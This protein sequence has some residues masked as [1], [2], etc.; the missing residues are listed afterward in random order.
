MTPASAERDHDATASRSMQ[1]RLDP[2]A[3]RADAAEAAA[4]RRATLDAAEACDADEL[5]FTFPVRWLARSEIRAAVARLLNEQ[6]SAALLPLH[7]SQSFDYAAPLRA[8]VD[9]RMRVHMRR[10]S[11]AAQLVL[12]AEIGPDEGIVHLRM[13]MVLRLFAGRESSLESQTGREP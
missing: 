1:L 9:Y 4:F 2:I 11:E 3:V 13:E 8:D 12:S 7:E 6:D 5:P 10:E